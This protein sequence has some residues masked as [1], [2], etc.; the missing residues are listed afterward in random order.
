MTSRTKLGIWT[1]FIIVVIVL[2]AK[3]SGVSAS[4]S[5][6]FDFSKGIDM[7]VT[8]N[9]LR[10]IVEGNLEGVEGD[11][12]VLIENM[13]G[14]EK[15]SMAADELFPAASLYKL[16]LL[17]TVLREVEGGSI[18]MGD[19]VSSSKAHLTSVYGSVDFGY[20][21]ASGEIEYTVE[22]ALTR[23]GR[24]SD[25]FAA[26]MLAEKLRGGL[27]SDPLVAMALELGM[28]STNLNPPGDEFIT[29]TASDVAV[30]FR[31]LY[32]GRV[33]SKTVSD[34]VTGFLALSKINDRIPVGLPDE[35]KVIH[36]TGELP[37]IRNDAG[38]VYLPGSAN[39]S[40]ASTAPPKTYLIVL[41]S[42]NLK[43]EDKGVEALAKISKE[44]YEYFSSKP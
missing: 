6:R 26:I 14:E 34:K 23:I 19:K 8:D 3:F 10:E 44:V 5:Y 36:K 12:A 4:K 37:R 11:F 16:V 33:V 41:L 32:A 18:K 17:A 15:Y 31:K 20:E 9:N 42:K 35:V 28:E 30:F 29:T 40:T 38:I 2:L 1:L 25:N 7:D 27:V 39:E 43:Y 13:A 24:I 21:D 22:E